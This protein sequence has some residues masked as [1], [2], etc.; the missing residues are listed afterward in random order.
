MTGYFAKKETKQFFSQFA[1][2]ETVFVYLFFKTDHKKNNEKKYF[3]K[4]EII[5]SVMQ[6]NFKYKVTSVYSLSGWGSE[7]QNY[8]I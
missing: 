1:H 5:E 6:S 2:V 7:D 8:G 4:S 3:D